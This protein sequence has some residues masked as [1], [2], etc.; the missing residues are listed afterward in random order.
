MTRHGITTLCPHCGYEHNAITAVVE[1]GHAGPEPYPTAG[2][3]TLCFGCGEFCTY[4]RS[5]MLRRPTHSELREIKRNK[6][7]QMVRESWLASRATRQ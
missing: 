7:C 5:D 6:C 4:D 2:D 1:R 3:Y